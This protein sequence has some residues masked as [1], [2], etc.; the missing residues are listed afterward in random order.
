MVWA[1]TCSGST[2]IDFD[3]FRLGMAF[4]IIL[5]QT[6]KRKRWNKSLPFLLKDL[7]GFLLWWYWQKSCVKKHSSCIPQKWLS[8]IA[9]SGVNKRV[10]VTGIKSTIYKIQ[11]S[12]QWLM[13]Q[14][15]WERLLETW[16]GCTRYKYQTKIQNKNTK[17]RV[18]AQVICERLLARIECTR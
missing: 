15:I 5:M 2:E 16:V 14:V 7:S 18:M 3:N 6:I 8:K 13:A 12:K 17:Q 1:Y 4:D 10:P 11:N 9:S